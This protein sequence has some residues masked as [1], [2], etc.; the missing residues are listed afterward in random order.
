MLSLANGQIEYYHK[1]IIHGGYKL[2]SD[3]D[4]CEQSI[5]GRHEETNHSGHNGRYHIQTHQQG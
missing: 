5:H 4:H 3:G 2:I 1:R